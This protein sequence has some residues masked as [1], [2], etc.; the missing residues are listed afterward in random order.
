MTRGL[1]AGETLS[2]VA[3]PPPHPPPFAARSSDSFAMRILLSLAARPFVLAAT[4]AAAALTLAG[5]SSRESAAT[6]GPAGG[7]VVV[8]MLG[9][10]ANL[11]PPL[12]ADVNEKAVQDMV[13][14]KLAEIGSDLSTIGD[15]GFAPRLAKSW[16]WAPDSLSIAFNLDPRA[17]WHDGAPVTAQDIR[18]SFTLFTDPKVGSPSASNFAN[19]D[20]VSVRDSATAVVWFKHRSPE[21][22]Y[23]FV[24]QLVPVPE[25]VYG[26]IPLEQL[27]TSDATRTLVGSGPFRLVKWE[28][29][30]RV[31]LVADTTNFRGRPKLDR[32]VIVPTTDPNAAFTQ[33]L[34]GQADF[35]Q[36]VPI[37]QT[38]T[39][40]SSKVARGIAVP[41]GGYAFLG[42]NQHARKS[43]T[44]PHPIFGDI[45]VRRALA[46]ATNRPAMLRNVFG[47]AGKLANGPAPISV[48]WLDTSLHV[49]PYDTA[50]A[51][52]ALDSAGWRVG[53]NGV[54]TKGG[55]ALQFSI[56]TPATSLQRRQYAVLLQDAFGKI[57]AKADIEIL[58]PQ[59]FIARSNSGDFDAE[60]LA[61]VP[62]PSIAGTT[63][64]WGKAGIGPTGQNTIGYYNPRVDA[65]I[66]SA[67][68]TFDVA[69]S[70][71][72]AGKA[73]QQI[74]DDV[75][76]IFLYDMIIID[77]VNRR[78]SVTDI[79]PDGWAVD[80]A[81]WSIPADKRIDR[82]R[83][84]LAAP[85]P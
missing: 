78:I 84:G 52:A 76:A 59:T 7:T 82:D 26:K 70:R 43:G 64:N 28:P 83:I 30:V 10:P 79:R 63:Q 41:T 33:L 32:I 36:G 55:R 58:D 57:G 72:A 38:P 1:G 35:L 2:R 65:L 27:H 46:M 54:R 71:A 75:P 69:Q 16:T 48:A 3:T 49:A 11:L 20:S 17:R 66:D 81:N 18:Y 40:D 77:G 74:V 21:A 29:R 9:D 51:A 22:F 31:E 73:F 50:A 19:I 39:L 45:K 62:D 80:I 37:D 67:T 47:N 44:A 24:Y 61:F 23:S 4:A 85:T 42:F 13:F 5:C 25:H 15:K 8:A 56:L 68:A 6:G 34:T 12:V 60:L 53:P 14:Y